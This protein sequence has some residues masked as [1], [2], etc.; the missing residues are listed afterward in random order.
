MVT[1]MADSR[2]WAVQTIPFRRSQAAY[3]LWHINEQEHSMPHILMLPITSS[4]CHMSSNGPWGCRASLWGSEDAMHKLSDL[5]S[6]C[7]GWCWRRLCPYFQLG[8]LILHD[9]FTRG[10]HLFRSA[11]SIIHLKSTARVAVLYCEGW[12]H[13][14]LTKKKSELNK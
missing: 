10:S 12:R 6:I 9:I 5:T 7:W 1:C 11:A 14:I 8:K 2:C 4:K 3:S 13:Q